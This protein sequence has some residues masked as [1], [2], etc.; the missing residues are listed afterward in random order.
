[1]AWVQDGLSELEKTAMDELLYIGAGRIENL[2]TTLTI[3][4]ILDSISKTEYEIIDWLGALD[5]RHARLVGELLTMPFLEE[6]DATDALALQAMHELSWD[7]TLS[8]LTEHPMFAEGLSDGDT[9]LVAAAGTLSRH[10]E[11]VTEL[12]N[13][14]GAAIETAVTATDRTPELTVSIVRT[15]DQARPGTMAATKASV[16]FVEGI[17]DLPLPVDHVIVVLHDKAVTEG[18]AGVNHGH[19]ISYLPE[20]ELR[21]DA[22]GAR[23]FR[24]GLVHEIAHYYWRGAEGWINEGVANIIEYMHGLDAGLSP[25]QLEPPRKNCEAH[26]L[27]MLSAWDPDPSDSRYRCNYYLGQ[28]LF[29]DLLEDMGEQTFGSALQELYL[30]FET[31]SDGGVKE[32]RQVFTGQEDIID[33]H[34]SGGINAP[35]SRPDEGI[36]RPSHDLIQWVM[37]PTYD[38]HSVT[39]EGRFLGDSALANT[40]PTAG[41]YQNFSLR[42]ADGRE[43]IGTILPPL[44]EGWS[45]TLDDPGDVVANG[46]LFSVTTRH[47]LVHFKFPTA[48]EGQPSDYV[49]VVWGYPTGARTP[50]IGNIVDILGYARIR[51]E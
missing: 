10:P 3:P 20:Y 31:T 38:G 45:W 12:L 2:E 29:L 4:W 41:G 44:S 5:Y 11:A 28:L 33:E 35:D 46:Y 24:I 9:T 18:Y 1:M 49:V 25:G 30:L 15:G 43:P 37:A 6:A 36:D 19:A 50:T 32:V 34:W 42:R 8:A 13:P 27:E 47:F 7:G 22:W 14:G 17:M 39:F 40:D 21:E 48:L 23:H 16:D 26:N 51:V